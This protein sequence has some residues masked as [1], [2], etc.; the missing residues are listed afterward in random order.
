MAATLSRPND[1]GVQ[2]GPGWG[3][4]QAGVQ[5]GRL[6]SGV[7]TSNSAVTDLLPRA[8]TRR[9]IPDTLSVHRRARTFPS[10]GPASRRYRRRCPAAVHGRRDV[11]NRSV[12]APCSSWKPPPICCNAG[13]RPRHSRRRPPPAATAADIAEQLLRVSGITPPLA[14]RLPRTALLFRVIFR[15]PAIWNDQQR[16]TAFPLS[17]CSRSGYRPV[18]KPVHREVPADSGQTPGGGHI[19]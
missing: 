17:R 16:G 13:H 11:A 4:R 9:R 10:R 12:H 3:R 1:L 15:A 6:V 18:P 14:A 5:V 19:T 8:R 2:C 7:P